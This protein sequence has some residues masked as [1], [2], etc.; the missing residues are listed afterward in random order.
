MNT[1][2]PRHPETYP[3]R[4]LLAI[5]GMTPQVVTETLYYLCVKRQPAFVPTDVY[6]ITTRVGHD[7]AMEHLLDH[8]D[9]EFHEFVKD[10]NLH[11]K[12]HF[13]VEK[14]LPLLDAEGKQLSDVRSI[15]DNIVAADIITEKVRK[16]TQDAD[17]AVH[18]SI[19]GGRNTLGLYL[20]YALSMFGR[21]QDRLSHVLVPW[22]F[23][24]N[25]E[26]FYPPP[27]HERIKTRGKKVVSTEHAH[28]T[29]AEIPFISLR[30]GLPQALLDGKASYSQTVEAIQ[31]TIGPP[32]ILIDIAK[33]SMVLGGVKIELPPQIFAFYL[34][35]CR[36]RKSNP[37]SGHVNWRTP[38]LAEDFLREYQ[39]LVGAMAHDLEEA[40][41]VLVDGMDQ[42]FFN[43]KKTRVK[44]WFNEL[45]G[46]RSS[47]YL[48]QQS[49]KRPHTT[50]GLTVN[51][52]AI[53]I[54]D[55]PITTL[56]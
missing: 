35:L 20:G 22:Q 50:Y 16:L 15:E 54:I 52:Q 23:E 51:A 49:G 32:T 17:S 37:H 14:F 9:G 28:V 42:D 33:K 8:E 56:S 46:A 12:I 45:L 48:I 30:H 47:P 40:R 53:E 4:I 36:K 26:F 19:S 43:E 1:S 41:R 13:T 25:D 27:V 39:L 34:L 24:G 11:G 18:I 55:V 29:L 38:G 6:L 5:G 10:Y 7:E 21:P 3:K 31:R 44:R 2:S